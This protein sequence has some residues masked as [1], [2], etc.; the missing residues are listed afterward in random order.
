MNQNKEVRVSFII[1]DPSMVERITNRYYENFELTV[2]EP[3]GGYSTVETAAIAVE[4]DNEARI[5]IEGIKTS[6]WMGENNGIEIK[7]AK[8]K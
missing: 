2:V 7:R 5:F 4:I 8:N 1:R 6:R 3:S